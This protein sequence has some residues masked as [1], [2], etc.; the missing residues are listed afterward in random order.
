MPKPKHLLNFY[1]KSELQ[2]KIQDKI[3]F[4]IVNKI[5]CK[6]LSELIR[7]E[8]LPVISE[9]TLY[10]IFIVENHKSTPYLHTLNILS[11]FINYAD[12]EDLSKV[13][14]NHIHFQMKY[15]QF[16]HNDKLT[17]SLITCCIESNNLS[18]FLKFCKQLPLYLSDE[19]VHLIGEE[20]YL[21]L[22]NNPN[23]DQ[24]IY[25]F[26]S[27]S[28]LP[29]IRKAFFE[30]MADPKFKIPHYSYGIECYIDNIQDKRNIQD[31]IFAKALLLINNVY[32]D[33]KESALMT[34]E[35]LYI[36]NTYSE[37]ELN[38]IYIYPCIRF[39]AYHIFY[40]EM[41]GKSI[42]SYLEYLFNYIKNRFHLWGHL[43][44]RIVFHTLCETLFLCQTNTEI[45]EKELKELFKDLYLYYPDYYNELSLQKLLIY[46][47]ANS[48]ATYK[49][50]YNQLN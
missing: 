15:G 24:N 14:N 26:K 18:P 8:N 45:Q 47:N 17:K 40:L 4:R 46:I 13:L 3:G 36:K 48:F 9:S 10:R 50:E 43:E 19:E 31:F 44:K 29:I 11:Q 2:N 28:H 12:W 39:L 7:N 32:K 49:L 30:F 21:A 27:A 41:I 16:N 38:S 5:D 34:A 37:D 35:E 1:C 22:L 33:D 6:K 42:A 23:P 20:I 25:F